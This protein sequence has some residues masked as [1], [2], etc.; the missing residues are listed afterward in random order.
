M[1]KTPNGHEIIQLFEA[2]S[3]KS[4]ALDGDPIG[5]HI[6]KLNKPVKKVMVTLDVLEDVVDEAIENEVDLIIAHH[7]PIYRPL[8]HVHTDKPSGRIVEKCIKHD[9]AV[10][11]AHT[12]LDVA[13]GG[14]NDLLANALQL[15]NTEVLIPTYEV[16]LK[17]LVVFVPEEASDTVRDALGSVGAGFIGNYSHC[18][19]MS[20]GEGAFMPHEGTN[21]Y[22][23]SE[24]QLE[25]VNEVRIETIFP[26]TLQKKVLTAMLKAHPYEEV[27][28]D[29]YPLENKGETMGLGKI[30]NLK[31][32]MSLREFSESVKKALDVKGLRV[33]GNL[34][35]RIKKV[36]VLG[37]D[38]N[39]YINTA[40]FK[41][42][43]V[44]VTGD[45]Y[46]HVAHD[47]MAMGLNIVDPG[48]NVEKVMKQGV[49]DY[50]KKEFD[51]HKFDVRIFPSAIN[52]DPFMF[53]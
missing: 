4:L 2:F 40:K 9:I 28:Y 47:A 22:I 14:V 8:K 39:K 25:K 27:A 19:F 24:W 29:I 26:A 30:G 45:I 11:A 52:T 21:P 13:I 12:N 7:P 32:E 38:G 37:G 53:I 50:L 36:A 1:M 48:H 6:G 44:Y 5:L 51:R 42:A 33:V 43:D 46:Y 49:T 15:E 20:P 10:Y 31:E 18:T 23:G 3:P 34:N 35:D 17:K 41:G 16:P